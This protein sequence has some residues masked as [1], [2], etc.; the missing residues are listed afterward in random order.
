[1][2][3]HSRDLNFWIRAIVVT[4]S[5]FA[6]MAAIRDLA[7]GHRLGIDLQARPC[8]PWR[9]YWIEPLP[10][11]EGVGRGELVSFR[12]ERMRPATANEA[13]KRVQGLPGDRVR[14]AN[15]HLYLNEA[16]LADL[17]VCRTTWR[18]DYCADRDYRLLQGEFLLLGD[19]EYSFDSRY[20]GPARRAEI[21]GR[22]RPLG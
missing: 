10:R 5:L 22:V 21:L 12:S 14:V 2:S 7:G 16:P 15:G 9:V 13:V 17:T 11:A 20:F 1:M 3:T 19:D 18:A 6:V 4:G 8:L